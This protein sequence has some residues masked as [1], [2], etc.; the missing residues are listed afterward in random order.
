MVWGVVVISIF[1]VVLRW[2]ACILCPNYHVRTTVGWDI[3]WNGAVLHVPPSSWLTM[4]WKKTQ[5]I[6]PQHLLQ[7]IRD[8]SHQSL[9]LSFRLDP[10]MWLSTSNSS[11]Q[12]HL[13]RL[14]PLQRYPSLLQ[15]HQHAWQF[16]FF[17]KVFILRL[18]YAGPAY[19]D[20]LSS[21]WSF[22]M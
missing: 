9:L 20:L 16:S 17:S 7:G 4:S 2:V 12:L 14:V 22:K 18:V 15:P 13:K 10:A 21:V 1:A 19:I 8:G 5:G 6:P 11:D 3:W